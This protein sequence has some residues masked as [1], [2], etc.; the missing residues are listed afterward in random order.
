MVPAWQM[1]VLLPLPVQF[2]AGGVLLKAWL[3]CSVE[4]V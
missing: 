4:G 1:K 2:A 3:P